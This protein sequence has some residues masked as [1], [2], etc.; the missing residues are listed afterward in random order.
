MIGRAVGIDSTDGLKLR[1]QYDDKNRVAAVVQKIDDSLVKTEYVYG[2]VEKQQKPGMLYGLKVDGT[3]R[4]SYT[5]DETG[6]IQTISENG[7]LK[8]TYHYDELNRLVAENNVW[9]DK[10]IFYTYDNGGNIIS[11]EEM[12]LATDG[13]IGTG[14]EPMKVKTC[15]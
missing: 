6:N 4:A 1:N 9:E 14:E 7:V 5:Y 2:E 12:E 8:C 3:E 11:W 10:S 15:E 13:S